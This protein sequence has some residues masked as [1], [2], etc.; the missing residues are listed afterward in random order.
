MSVTT[1]IEGRVA[2][3]KLICAG[4]AHL[5][6]ADTAFMLFHAMVEIDETPNVDVAVITGDA[7]GF[8]SGF[9]LP[10]GAGGLDRDWM[11]LMAVPKDWSDPVAH[12]IPAP[13]GPTRLMVSKPVI[14]AIE[15]EAVAG[16]L[17][18]A[19]WCD[20]RVAAQSAYLGAFGR[21]RGVPMLDG[22]TSRL[23]ALIGRGR[24]MDMMMTGRP[25]PAE[26]AQEIGLVD[27]VVADGEA[28]AAAK[29][30]ARAIAQAPQ[31]AMHA[32]L[33]VLRGTAGDHVGMFRRE[34]A[35]LER[36]KTEIIGADAAPDLGGK[37][38][39]H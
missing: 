16:G 28:L 33:A 17:E 32:D 15:G 20:M 7:R 18:L 2:I 19:L 35:A 5:L 25:V 34:W 21:R 31:G 1:V 23:P 27:R 36:Y 30:L 26:E 6:D 8:S 11:S 9:T 10:M 13:M 39:H 24:A 37:Y 4:D 29:D 22:G 14:A 12:K 3:V 38:K